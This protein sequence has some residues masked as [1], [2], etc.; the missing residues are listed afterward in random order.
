MESITLVKQSLFYSMVETDFKFVKAP[1]HSEIETPDRSVGRRSLEIG[2][3]R[4]FYI[5]EFILL[6]DTQL[7]QVDGKH[8]SC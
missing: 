7:A 6:F 3:K 1:S 5:L 4:H 8:H 2:K